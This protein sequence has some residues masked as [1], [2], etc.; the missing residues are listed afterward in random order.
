MYTIYYNKEY[1]MFE[2]MKT[3]YMHYIYTI[4]STLYITLVYPPGR[5]TTVYSRSVTGNSSNL[6]SN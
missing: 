4:Y 5:N 2:D 3:L 6:Y 1:I